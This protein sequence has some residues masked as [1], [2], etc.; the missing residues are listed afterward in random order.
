MPHRNSSLKIT[1]KVEVCVDFDRKRVM[2][3][4]ETDDGNL[5]DVKLVYQTINKIHDELRKQTQDY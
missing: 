2:V 3:S 4:C 1:D 5:L